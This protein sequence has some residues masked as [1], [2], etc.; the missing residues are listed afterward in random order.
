MRW[1]VS[2]V[3]ISLQQN[4]FQKSLENLRKKLSLQ[5]KASKETEDRKEKLYAKMLQD[6][7]G[8]K[9]AIWRKWSEKIVLSRIKMPQK[10]SFLLWYSYRE[11]SILHFNWN[12][13]SKFTRFPHKMLFHRFSQGWDR[14]IQL[15]SMFCTSNS[16]CYLKV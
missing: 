6:L 5:E 13:I 12:G 8:W 11:A 14:F 2:H 3:Q 4:D 15:S 9:M 10:L 16:V 1:K 7:R